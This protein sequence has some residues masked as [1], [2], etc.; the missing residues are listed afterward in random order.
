MSQSQYLKTDKIYA[1]FK[2]LDT[3]GS[4]KIDKNELKQILGK[5][6]G[7]VNHE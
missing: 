1:T 5:E 4:G 2:M 7:L 3:D 6:K